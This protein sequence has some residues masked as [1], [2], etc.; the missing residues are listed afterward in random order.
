MGLAPFGEAKRLGVSEALGGLGATF[1]LT[2][3]G[4]KTARRDKDFSIPTSIFRKPLP[5]SRLSAKPLT[6]IQRRK[7]PGGGRLITRGE[8]KE[9][10]RSRRRK[11][12]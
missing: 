9:I 11:K 1:R 3:T 12:K 5:T 8:R 10:Q 7:A 6:F 2:P 4:K